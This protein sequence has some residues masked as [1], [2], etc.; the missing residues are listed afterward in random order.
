[1]VTEHAPSQI[2]RVTTE[3]KEFIASSSDSYVDLF[4][5]FEVNLNV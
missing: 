5:T 2:N 3:E 1:M 4:E